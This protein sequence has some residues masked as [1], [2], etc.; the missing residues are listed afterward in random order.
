MQKRTS[1]LSATALLALI[2]ACDKAPA[3]NEAVPAD[4]SIRSRYPTIAPANAAAL[5]RQG[6]RTGRPAG[7]NALITPSGEAIIDNGTVQL[8]VSQRGNLNVAGG[9]RSAGGTSAT[10][11]RYMATN[12][13]ATAPG[14]LC[15]GWG[16]ADAT[17]PTLTGYANKAVGTS[18]L[19]IVSFT[20]T[21]S[22]ARSVVTA[23][24][25]PGKRLRVT[26]EFRPA[27]ATRNLYE[28]LV[29]IENTG[30]VD[31]GD[32]RYRRTFDWDV[33]PTPFEEFVTIQGSEDAENVRAA[34][35]NGFASS[36]P[37]VSAGGTP[38]D[39]V[40]LGP[41]DHGSNFD[42][43]FGELEV[44][45]TQ[46]FTIFY[47][48]AGTE[49]GAINALKAVGAEVYSLGQP[50][51][52]G[53]KDE[54]TPNTFAFGFKGVGGVA[55]NNPPVATLTGPATGD[56][57]A[58]LSFTT[59]ATDPDGDTPITCE[60][61][62][63]D[64]TGG[65]IPCVGSRTHTFAAAGTYSVRLTARDPFGAIGTATRSVTIGGGGPPVCTPNSAPSLSLVAVY[66]RVAVERF[67]PGIPVAE[68]LRFRFAD[69]NCG[70]WRARVDWGNGVVNEFPIS[71]A[72][73]PG[74][75]NIFHKYATA[76]RYTIK[77]KITDEGGLASP[78]QS[79]SYDVVI[80]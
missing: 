41:F 22:T 30:T 59:G 38:G 26:H 75:Y 44:G 7:V 73:G 77:M 25:S 56:A 8:G 66:S 37:L 58:S 42:F 28:V 50:S 63:G 61:A 68:M 34:T 24:S 20:A 46:R 29:T 48:A 55:I 70:P 65:A 64:G 13:E 69:A 11:L 14:C 21:G 6:A 62:W 47:G 39:F 43:G 9:T 33:E 57:G 79:I 35:N 49:T 60:I 3:P 74:L 19:D 40:D 1:L 23:G 32:L 45:E 27:A 51:A 80:P 78:E 5:A 15:E 76:G 67:A 4:A 53:G 52:T 2:A 72:L 10:G 12:N 71:R 54:G 36:N 16:V 17:S 18:G 31:I